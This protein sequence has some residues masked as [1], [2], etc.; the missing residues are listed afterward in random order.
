MGFEDEKNSLASDVKR[1][2]MQSGS[3]TDNGDLI[4]TKMREGF[5]NGMIDIE[6]FKQALKWEKK[7]EF[8]EEERD[9]LI[10]F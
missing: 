2:I 9:D 4:V 3:L 7:R 1:M 6:I 10:S 5:G 8:F